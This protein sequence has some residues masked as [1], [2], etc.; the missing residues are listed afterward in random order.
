MR[1]RWM[2]AGLTAILAIALFA[3]GLILLGA[4]VTVITITRVM[5]MLMWQRRRAQTPSA[6]RQ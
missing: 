4:I 5:M 3:S 1:L 6:R 2:M